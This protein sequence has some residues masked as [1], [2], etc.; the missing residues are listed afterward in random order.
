MNFG[1]SGD[2]RLPG[3]ALS[4]GDT[5]RIFDI[6]AEPMN[7]AAHDISVRELAE[8]VYRKGDLGGES[9]FRRSN[10]ALE[11]I[12]GHKRI[13]QSRGTDY[14]P[15]V[16]VER[17][18]TKDEVALRVVG[19]V[20]GVIEGLTPLVEE[21][22]TV[23]PSWSKEADPVHWA[24]LRIYGGI[25]ALEKGWLHVSLQL[26]YL[27]LDSHEVFIFREEASREVLLDFLN[28]T[29]DEWFAWLIPYVDWINKRNA[30]AEKAPFPFTTFRAGQRELARSVYRAIQSKRTSFVEA[31]TGLGK[32]MATLYPSIK[33]LPLIGDGK[34]FYVT[35]KTP[36]RLAAQDALQKLRDKGVQVRSVS[37]TAKAKICFAPDASGC[38]PATCPFLKG[39]YDRYKPAMRELLAMQKLDRDNISIVAKKYQVCP[40]EL[41]LDVSNWVDVIVGDYN[42]V[43]DPTVTLQ[44]YFGE[45]RAKHVVLIDEAHNLVDRSREMYSAALAATDLSIGGEAGK[46]STKARRSLASARDELQALLR[47][48]PT[49]IPQPKGYHRG[50]F[51]VEAIPEALIESLRGLAT[52]IEAFLIGSSRETALP[53]LDPYFTIHRFLQ[54]A[55]IFD[56]TYRLI[57]DP[58]SQVV[59]LFCVDP[60]KRLAQSLKGLR[61]AVFFS[62]TLSPIDYFVD[63]LGG[64]TDSMRS[65]YAS[66][67]RSDQMS[68]RIAPFDVSFHERARS[69]ESVVEAIRKH[70]RENP[71]NNLIYCPSL[72]YLEQ[73]HQKLTAVEVTAFAQRP[74][75]AESE[76]ES[77]L[78]KFANGTGSVGLAVL[79]GIFA[80]GIDLPGEQLVGVTVIGV[81]FPS[82]SIERDLLS[83]YFDHKEKSGIDYAYR[84]PGMQRVLQAVGRLIRSEDDQGGVL[85]IDRRFLEARY[86]A[87]FPTWWS[88]VASE[89][90]KDWDDEPA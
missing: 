33:A 27:E 55:G 15:E 17:S 47:S 71:G 63:V 23:E 42:Y 77:F 74:G 11:G 12:K 88:V 83:A 86:E 3:K 90:R 85:L 72:A 79:G 41:S 89:V 16:S 31:P 44:R 67:F 26:T 57:V 14:Q 62:A 40:F 65:V 68:V 61:S 60:S 10:R 81:G 56:E 59:T 52:T 48:T 19:R 34:I 84:F 21:I 76:R 46:V 45:G 50:A 18:F 58:A 28:E 82:L 20:D 70:L 53:W 30:S 2:F 66:P 80:E 64:S 29:V 36:G 87:L 4:P 51:A 75:M 25:L 38:D 35:A 32:T 1:Q 39:Y 43:F 49:G 22:K 54:V 24:Q 7:P 13:Q 6:L 73:L 5:G 37:L 69:M 8:F 78:A 9:T